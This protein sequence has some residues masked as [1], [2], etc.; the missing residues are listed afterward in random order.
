LSASAAS[1]STADPVPSRLLRS[2]NVII[3]LLQIC[4][5]RHANGDPIKRCKN[6]AMQ[7]SFPAGRGPENADQRVAGR[8]SGVACPVS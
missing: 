5:A 3:Q 7:V 4:F 2:S 1:A 8:L 6:R